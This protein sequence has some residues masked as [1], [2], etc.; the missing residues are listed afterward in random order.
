MTGFLDMVRLA[1]HALAACLIAASL[2][3]SAQ[4]YPTKPVRLVVPTTPGGGTDLAARAI[5]PKLSEYLGQQVLIDNRPGATT[6]I[7]GEFVARSEPD[8]YTLLMGVSSLTIV[9]HILRGLR[10]DPMTAFTPVSQVVVSPNIIVAHPSLPTRSVQELIAFARA[11]PGQL[12]FAAGG[13]GSS[14]H[15]AIELFLSMTGLK[16][17][18]VPYKGQGPAL[19]DT[20]AGHV[21]LMMANV[22]SALP[23]VKDKRLRALGV[24][25]PKRSA[26]APGI[27]TIAE[28]GVPG[29]EV[30]QWYGVLAPAK[31]PRSIIN[32][33]HAVT[34]RAVQD[35]QIK[36]RFISD[37]GETVGNTPE[38][39]AAIIQADYKK[40]GKVVKDAG[41][42]VNQR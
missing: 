14:Q 1:C 11:R 5:Q 28:A 27:P 40:W 7:G 2:S 22:L 36:R 16:M 34:V 41:I 29:Y 17:V 32:K 9:P 15:L 6:T 31:T 42:K 24:T 4:D 35:P 10:Y 30:L 18:H 19:I 23:H 21:S 33:I 39:F 8:G 38:E 37:G 12:N 26:I 3:A 13:A 20:I 25:G